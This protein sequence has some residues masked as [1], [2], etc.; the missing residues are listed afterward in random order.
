MKQALKILHLEDSPDDSELVRR[1]LAKDGLDCAIKRVESREQFFDEIEHSACDMILADCA[2]PSFSGFRALEIARAL[3]PHVPFIFVSGTLGE[4]TA[5]KSLQ[6]GATDYVLKDRLSRLVP[7][8]RR[9]LTDAKEKAMLRTMKARLDQARRLKVV[10][11]FGSLGSFTSDLARDFNNLLRV[12]NEK[13]DEISAQSAHGHQV[14]DIGQ[15]LKKMAGHGLERLEELLQ[16]A[17]NDDTRLIALAPHQ[18]IGEIVEGQKHL[19]PVNVNIVLKLT[20]DLPDFTANHAKINRILS[21]LIVNAREA[22][23][24]GGTITIGGEVIRFDDGGASALPSSDAIYFCLKV[25]DTGTGMDASTRQRAFEPF[26]TTK[27]RENKIGLGLSVVFGLMQLHNGLIDI[28]SAP[29]KGTSVSLY[30]PLPPNSE[31]AADGIK[32]IPP[33][34]IAPEILT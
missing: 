28:E 24:D 23:P 1:L 31:I 11:T 12:I 3:K 32:S 8:I 33:I 22:M 18:T 27:P 19:L 4:E 6:N 13:A 26:F 10:G 29:G 7:S 21:N 9:A 34:Q 17:R 14:V 5:I 25:S 20:D 2:L 15:A 30:F 16:F